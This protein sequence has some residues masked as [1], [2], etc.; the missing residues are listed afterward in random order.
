M[1]NRFLFFSTIGELFLLAVSVFILK[2]F[3]QMP[4]FYIDSLGIYTSVLVGVLVFLL[5]FY[6]SKVFLFAKRIDQVLYINVFKQASILEM[7]YISVLSAF[8]EEMF[9]RGLMQEFLG[10]YAASIFFGILHTPEISIKGLFYAIYISF[11]GFILGV[12]YTQQ[13]SILAPMIA[14]F[15]I[16]FLG[17]IHL[18]LYNKFL[19]GKD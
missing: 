3:Q 1:K 17:I 13:S 15:I 7:F 18:T 4:D 12:L 11:I 19:K 8:S 10:I 5:G 2:K 6:I 9:F 16:N 14:H